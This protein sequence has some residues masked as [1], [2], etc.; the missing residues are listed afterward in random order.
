MNSPPIL[1]SVVVPPGSGKVLR[2]FGD[3]ITVHLGGKETG[4]KFTMFTTLTP[5]G[6]GPPPHYHTHEDEWFWPMEGRVEFLV[7]DAWTEVS[8][9]TVVFV[10]RGVVHA[11]RNSGQT[12]LR[13]LI[14][15]APSGFE[16]FFSRCADEFAKPVPLDMQRIMAISAEHGIFFVNG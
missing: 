1:P 6:S 14:H 13:M 8:L 10:P 3:E 15:T 12:P 11:F 2:A 5:P 4:G 16:N 7:D 9:G